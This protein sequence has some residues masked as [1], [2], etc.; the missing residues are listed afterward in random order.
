L[1]QRKDIMGMI[2]MEKI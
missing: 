1:E 2:L